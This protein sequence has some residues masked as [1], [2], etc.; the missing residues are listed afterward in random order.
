MGLPQFW[1]TFRKMIIR[2]SRFIANLHLFKKTAREIRVIYIMTPAAILTWFLGMLLATESALEEKTFVPSYVYDNIQDV[3]NVVNYS[4]MSMALTK[5]TVEIILLS[6]I[7]FKL[8]NSNSVKASFT[9]SL[10]HI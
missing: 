9:L 1:V 4:T 3:I 10:I 2:L 7:A 8:V 5:N 6:F